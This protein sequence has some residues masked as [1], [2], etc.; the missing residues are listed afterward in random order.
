VKSRAQS[1]ATATRETQAVLL[2]DAEV[3][4]T[5]TAGRQL[6]CKAARFSALALFCSGTSAARLWLLHVQADVVQ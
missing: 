2:L 3:H 5:H 4:A 6:T 1:H